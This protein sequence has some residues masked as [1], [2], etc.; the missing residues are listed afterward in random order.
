MT[1]IFNDAKENNQQS[2]EIAWSGAPFV[3]EFTRDKDNKIPYFGFDWIELDNQLSNETSNNPQY[4]KAIKHH[5]IDGNSTVYIKNNSSTKF[6]HLLNEKSNEYDEIV[7]EMTKFSNFLNKEFTTCTYNNLHTS[8]QWVSLPNVNTD[9]NLLMRVRA[10]DDAKISAD[11]PSQLFFKIPEGIKI[12]IN[13]TVFDSSTTETKYEI[14]SKKDVVPIK[15]KYEGNFEVNQLYKFFEVKVYHVNPNK[16]DSKLAIIGGLKIQANTVINYPVM[17]WPSIDKSKYNK[18]EDE[19]NA[20]TSLKLSADEL[21][22]LNEKLQQTFQQAGIN[23][24]VEYAPGYITYDIKI[25]DST[26]DEEE[27]KDRKDK[28]QDGGGKIRSKVSGFFFN[29]VIADLERF[30]YGNKPEGFNIVTEDGFPSDFKGSHLLITDRDSWYYSPPPIEN[31]NNTGSVATVNLGG[32]PSGTTTINGGYAHLGSKFCMLFKNAKT[33]Y[34]IYAHEIGHTLGCAHTFMDGNSSKKD[35]LDR[36]DRSIRSSKYYATVGQDDEKFNAYLE[37]NPNEKQK[38][39]KAKSDFELA[40]DKRSVANSEYDSAKNDS[41]KEIARNK[42]RAADLERNEASI[43]EEEVYAEYYN[44]MYLQDESVI[45]AENDKKELLNAC[46]KILY[47][48]GQTSAS[49]TS[50]VMD[51]YSNH[52]DFYKWQWLML[53]ITANNHIKTKN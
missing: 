1:L 27:E 53:R 14:K 44:K 46:E 13:G 43:R 16:E 22:K 29:R 35:D 30:I 34:G 41:E 25:Y 49:N 39:E 52:D 24:T 3:V 19:E 26:R 51:Y 10:S 31:R 48:M 37:K 15:L 23:M 12:T 20:V 7:N 17:I 32:G 42:S 9:I 33:S 21:V 5:G 4:G 2:K 28:Y 11:S 36:K 6:S 18:I 8:I 40:T 38:L 50:N 47:I 45:K